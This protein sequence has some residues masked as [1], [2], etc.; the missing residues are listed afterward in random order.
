MSETIHAIQ[1]IYSCLQFITVFLPDCTCPLDIA[2]EK[3]FFNFIQ[4]IQWDSLSGSAYLFGPS[5]FQLLLFT[6]PALTKYS[7]NNEIHLFS[8]TSHRRLSGKQSSVKF[9]RL[10]AGAK[11]AVW[12]MMLSFCFGD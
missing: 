6:E 10:S 7:S 8:S 3:L 5:I 9:D 12:E 1:M 11:P 4:N 2:P